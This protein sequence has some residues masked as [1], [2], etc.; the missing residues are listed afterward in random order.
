MISADR[1]DEI[2]KPVEEAKA[3]FTAH[4]DLDGEGR[5]YHLKTDALRD[6]VFMVTQVAFLELVAELRDH[7]TED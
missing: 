6:R 2:A 5:D 4:Y 3:R 7:L 1:L